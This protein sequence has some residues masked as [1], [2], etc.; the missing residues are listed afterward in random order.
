MTFCEKNIF[1]KRHNQTEPF[2]V[3]VLL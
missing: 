1:I 2:V 3:I